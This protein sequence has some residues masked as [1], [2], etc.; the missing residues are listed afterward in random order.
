MKVFAMLF[1]IF[2]LMLSTTLSSMATVKK[3]RKLLA[4]GSQ[5]VVLN[6][7]AKNQTPAASQPAERTC[8]NSTLAAT[9]EQK[10]EPLLITLSTREFI[11]VKDHQYMQ[12]YI[13]PPFAPP[14]QE[15]VFSS[16]LL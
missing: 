13:T 16:N 3:C 15:K 11:M 9:T 12:Q 5:T 4:A 6:S 7:N 2:A 14:R 10:K 8:D 1:G